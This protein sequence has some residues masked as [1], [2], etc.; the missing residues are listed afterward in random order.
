MA[1]SGRDA[2]VTG[3]TSMTG[4]TLTVV[5]VRINID[6][7]LNIADFLEDVQARVAE[8]RLINIGP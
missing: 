8:L 7:Q 3:I 4:P 5:P 6:H 1:L 2:S